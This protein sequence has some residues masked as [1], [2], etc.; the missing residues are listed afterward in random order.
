MAAALNK[1]AAAVRV[2]VAA[3]AR[4]EVTSGSGLEVTSGSGKWKDGPRLCK[5]GEVR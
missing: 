5:A 1:K 2:L 4:L 3:G